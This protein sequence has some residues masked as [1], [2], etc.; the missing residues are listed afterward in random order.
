M[1]LEQN[2]MQ[3][4]ARIWQSIAQSGVDLSSIP[5]EQLEKMVSTIAD[6]ALLSL[7][8]MLGAAGLEPASSAESTSASADSEQILW[9]GRPFLSLVEH[10]TITSER[11]QIRGGLLSKDHEDIELVRLQ[12]IDFT[13]RITERM[14]NI[15]DIT[16][17]STDGSRPE[18]VLRNVSNPASVHE[19]IR[20]A[21][22]DAR[23][24]YRV[25]FRQE[26]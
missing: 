20:R 4:T 8:E 1:S 9:E 10:Y 15:G 12:D 5:R 23:K 24:R 11:I 18:V 3:L 17:R 16:L 25:G 22:L 2:R 26:L 14:I 21:M 13:Q 7:D 19:I 6:G